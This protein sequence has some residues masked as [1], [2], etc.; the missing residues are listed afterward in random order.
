[1]ECYNG[2]MSVQRSTQLFRELKAK[3]A[4]FGFESSLHTNNFMALTALLQ[5]ALRGAVLNKDFQLDSN[6]YGSNADFK[7]YTDHAELAERI[8]ILD[9]NVRAPDIDALLC[10][11]NPYEAYEQK[12]LASGNTLTP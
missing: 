9:Q 11:D 12:V 8:R 7:V 6:S 5:I 3:K 1:M 2:N 4:K 10:G